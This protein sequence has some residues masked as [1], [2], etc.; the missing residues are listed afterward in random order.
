V[1]LEG[2]GKLKNF[3]DLL[4]TRIRDLPACSKALQPLTLCLHSKILAVFYLLLISRS[5]LQLASLA[6]IET[7]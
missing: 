3:Y 5:T 6:L 1:Q 2:L 4:G 7:V